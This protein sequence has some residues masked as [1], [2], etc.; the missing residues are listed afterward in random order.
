[1]PGDERSSGILSD[2]SEVDRRLRLLE[3]G[4]LEPLG[5]LPRSTNYTFL[6][7]VRDGEEEALAVYKPRAG[8]APL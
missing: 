5:L 1:M 7:R 2:P 3:R 6:A 4:E 8:E